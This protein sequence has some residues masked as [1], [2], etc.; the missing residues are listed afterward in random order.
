MLALSGVLVAA[1]PFEAVGFRAANDQPSRAASAEFVTLTD[2]E[3]QEVM[4]TVKASWQGHSGDFRRLRADL[5]VGELPE[6][7]GASLPDEVTHLPLAQPDV[8]DY[9]VVPYRPTAG[10]ERP[11]AIPADEAVP[12]A[13]AFP[14]EELLRI[15]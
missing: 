15:E 4:R 13:P 3:M 11:R 14:R 12:P 6:D 1:F 5:S 10:A 7:V 9:P 8:V 2:D